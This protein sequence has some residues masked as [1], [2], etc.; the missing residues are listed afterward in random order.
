MLSKRK[1]LLLAS[2]TILQIDLRHNQLILIPTHRLD[3]H[4]P[5]R[6][7]DTTPPDERILAIIHT[8]PRHVDAETRIRVTAVL[9]T[10]Q[11][12]EQRLVV[13][14]L[15]VLD[16]AVRAQQVWRP[17]RRVVPAAHDLDALQAEHAPG[18]GPAAVVA[19]QRADYR[20]AFSGGGGR[21]VGAGAVGGS[22]CGG[23]GF[24]DGVGEEA[25]GTEGFEAEVSRAEVA[26]LQLLGGAGCAVRFDG[27]WE[28]DFAV[29]GNHFSR[30]GGEVHGRVVMRVLVFGLA[31][32]VLGVADADVDVVFLG[33]VE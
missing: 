6:I 28:M 10:E 26:F 32:V 7:D 33:L 11:V 21:G 20:V 17:R 4:I 2:P 31:G 27:A 9:Q 19:D 15:F 3:H 18:L 5:I 29:F 12:V 24:L 30:G 14:V 23:G 25:G 8:A 13:R 1:N 22:V 16:L